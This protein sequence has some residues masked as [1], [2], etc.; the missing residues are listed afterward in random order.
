MCFSITHHVSSSQL[1]WACYPSHYLY[2]EQVPHAIHIASNPNGLFTHMMSN[3]LIIT[4]HPPTIDPMIQPSISK[5]LETQSHFLR[6]HLSIKASFIY[7]Y[8][9]FQNSIL[10]DGEYNIMFLEVLAMNNIF[11]RR[12]RWA[13]RMVLLFP[14]GFDSKPTQHLFK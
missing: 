6:L 3:Q 12:E 9:P 5:A 8:I 11:L 7:Y 1:T 10:D 14:F 2:F 13:K 4:Y